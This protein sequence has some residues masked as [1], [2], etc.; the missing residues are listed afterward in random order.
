MK[1]IISKSCEPGL[2]LDGV[3]V[4]SWDY[5]IENE[6][7]VIE[8]GILYTHYMSE[9][10]YCEMYPEEVEGMT[11]TDYDDLYQNAFDINEDTSFYVGSLVLPNDGTIVALGP[12]CFCDL[13]HLDTVILPDCLEAIYRSAFATSGIKSLD[14]PNSVRHI[15]RNAFYNCEHLECIKLPENLESKA[16]ITVGK[17]GKQIS[18][19]VKDSA[20]E[21]ENS[22]NEVLIK[23]NDENFT[24]DELIEKHTFKET[25]NLL[26]LKNI[27]TL[28]ENEEDELDADVPNYVLR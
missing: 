22:L 11:E 8:D 27:K 13:I 9:E 18:F 24:L 5:I 4:H 2:Y 15:G 3:L 25:N 6:Y 14:I 23:L 21:N 28:S 26:K 17:L 19:I 1:T 16:L 12:C 10:K 7:A 20:F